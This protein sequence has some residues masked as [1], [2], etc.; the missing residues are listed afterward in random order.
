MANVF[1]AWQTTDELIDYTRERCVLRE[2]TDAE[3]EQFGL[4]PR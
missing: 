2:L 1:P 3:R 4:G